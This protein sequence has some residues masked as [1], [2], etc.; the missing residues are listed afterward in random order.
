MKPP[1]P[2]MPISRIRLLQAPLRGCFSFG[3]IL[4]P[5]VADRIEGDPMCVKILVVFL[6]AGIAGVCQSIVPAGKAQT[7]TGPTG[8]R[9]Q[10]INGKKVL[11][12]SVSNPAPWQKTSFA[13]SQ[14]M[15]WED[16]QRDVQSLFSTPSAAKFLTFD[17]RLNPELFSAKVEPPR[18][19]WPNAK[20]LP[21]PT[22]WPNAKIEPIPTTW[23]GFKIVPLAYQQGVTAAMP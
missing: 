17:P 8:P 20:V 2:S 9:P 22:V 21:I 7:P 19:H 16:P 15:R 11:P 13:E 10:L 12:F 14:P 18:V 23:P 1:G 4:L 5:Q 3:G 6:V